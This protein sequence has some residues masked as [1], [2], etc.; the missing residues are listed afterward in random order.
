ML[1]NNRI[2]RVSIRAANTDV[3]PIN[4]VKSISAIDVSPADRRVYWADSRM[5]TIS[6]GYI[7]GSRVEKIVSCGLQSPESVALDWL[8]WNVYWADASL[9]RIEVVTL[10]GHYRRTL[11]WSNLNEPRNL[12]VDPRVGF[13][14]WSE[15]SR[16]SGIIVKAHMDGSM[17]RAIVERIGRVNGLTIDYTQR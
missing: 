14:F 15:W 6:R 9:K 17:R 3:I 10:N 12:V 7:N 11:F 8:A 13:M 5:K 1:S 4:E 2:R 16:D